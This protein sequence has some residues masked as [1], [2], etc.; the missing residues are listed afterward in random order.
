VR[1]LCFIYFTR[2]FVS[3]KL[4][5]RFTLTEGKSLKFSTQAKMFLSAATTTATATPT[6]TATQRRKNPEKTLMFFVFF[7]AFSFFE[8]QDEGERVRDRE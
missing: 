5:V 4:L 1:V 8:Q 3:F 2:A 6:A 7:P